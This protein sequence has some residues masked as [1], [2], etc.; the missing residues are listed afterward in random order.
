MTTDHFCFHLQNRL[1]HTSQEEVNS[2][3][4][5]PPLAFPASSI[6]FDDSRVTLQIVASLADYSRGVNYYRNMFLVV[7]TART[8]QGQPLLAL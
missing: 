6:V 2:T 3:V 4:I 7:A 8:C 1:I 5:L